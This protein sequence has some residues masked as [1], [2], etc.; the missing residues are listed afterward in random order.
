MKRFEIVLVTALVVTDV[1]LVAT[2]VAGDSA[3]MACQLVANVSDQVI[4]ALKKDPDL[5]QRRPNGVSELLNRIVAPH[6]DFDAT[7]TLVLGRYWRDASLQQRQLFIQAFRTH[8]VQLC[9][10]SLAKYKDQKIEYKPASAA[11]GADGVVVVQTEVQQQAGSPIPV[12][13]RLHRKGNDWKVYDV[14][15]DGVS[16]VASNRSSFAE[17]IR[18]GGIDALTDRL[19]Q[20]NVLIQDHFFRGILSRS[21][22]PPGGA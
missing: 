18:Q 10:V 1:A 15:V 7:A 17:E 8:L 19:A 11:A 16:M 14:T 9:A 20:L 4:Q 3:A 6:F 5:A 21:R 13:Y 22:A 12:D 2:D